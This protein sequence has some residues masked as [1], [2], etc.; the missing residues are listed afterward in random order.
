MCLSA[1]AMVL[2]A[3]AATALPGRAP[4]D[5]QHHLDSI[6]SITSV[7]DFADLAERFLLE[8]A[9]I[10]SQMLFNKEKRFGK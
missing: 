9:T 5:D 2:A 6:E 7:L 3:V 4:L 10:D 8:G 1:L